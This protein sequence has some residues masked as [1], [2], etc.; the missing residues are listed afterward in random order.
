MERFSPDY[1]R[2]FVRLFEPHLLEALGSDQ[3]H[4]LMTG[5][6]TP[7]RIGPRGDLVTDCQFVLNEP[8][9][10]DTT[11]QPAY[12]DNPKEIYAGLLLHAEA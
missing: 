3:L 11:T 1:L 10:G 4:Q 12:V 9:G 5:S 8:G 7:R 6:G 2:D